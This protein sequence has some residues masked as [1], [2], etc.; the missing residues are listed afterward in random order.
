MLSLR[1]AALALTFLCFVLFEATEAFAPKNRV[2]RRTAAAS[3]TSLSLFGF[4]KEGKK[5]LVKSLAGD[6]DD[7]VI[8]SRLDGLVNEN[9]VL[10]LR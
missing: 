8:K 9:P 3:S 2:V 10:M 6:Y 1:R 5:L 7:A 4:L